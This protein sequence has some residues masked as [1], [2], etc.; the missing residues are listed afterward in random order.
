MEQHDSKFVK[1]DHSGGEGARCPLQERYHL[2]SAFQA[3][4]LAS[5]PVWPLFIKSLIRHCFYL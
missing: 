5:S 1:P 4:I 3:S 2:L